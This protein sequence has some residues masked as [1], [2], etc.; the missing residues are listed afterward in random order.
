MPEFW[1]TNLILKVISGSR[2]YGLDQPDSD[3]DT[4]AVCIP[5]IEYLL[6]LKTFEQHENATG[7]HVIFA[8]AKFVRLA[9]Q[10]N[11][12]IIEVLYTDPAD[13]L[14]AD[15]FGER[16]L[17]TREI[18]LS[19]HVGETFSRYAIAQL[20][21]MENHH[22]W[23]IEPPDQQPQPTEFGATRVAGRFR[24]PDTDRER[25]YRAALKHWNNY[26]VWRRNRNPARAKLEEKHGY[27]TK[28]AMHLLRLLHMGGEILREGVV[29]VKRPDA[30]WLKS[31]RHGALTYEEVIDLAARHEATLSASIE[32]SPLPSE[33]DTATAD[34]LTIELQQEFLFPPG[35]RT[36]Y[37]PS[38][39]LG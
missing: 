4:R 10:G 27:D 22:R 1:E 30:A 13:V 23:L 8:L 35:P 38:I 2:A 7:D 32:Q 28:H 15:R 11:P 21:R 29:R 36:R 16:L 25:A 31:V 18:F 26:Q 5:P 3:T 9:L 20:R 14:F 24:F 12:N 37:G 39:S 6:G 34:Q 19:R 33:P 17:A